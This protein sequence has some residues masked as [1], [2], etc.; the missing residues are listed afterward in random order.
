MNK[1]SI[2]SN[3]I[4]RFAER[5][6]AQFVTFF[7]SIILAR[8]LEPKVYGTVAIVTIFITIL[9]VFVD[10][11]LGNA[12][13]QKKDADSKDY[14]SVFY[15][16]IVFCIVIYILLF[17]A[18]PLI[19]AFYNLPELTSMIRVMGFTIIISGI[20]NVQQ[21]YVSKNMMFKKFFFSTLIGT[22][23]AA[24]VGIYM[25]FAGFGVWAII[26][27]NLVNQ[28]IDT[29]ILWKTVKWRPTREF[30]FSRLKSLFSYG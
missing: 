20:K 9:Q 12:L 29:A 21:A 26:V 7:V 30:S 27:Q 13:I 16:N 3:L 6:G 18:A 14:S 4:W 11:G 1:N 5:C 22:I 28:L 24:V 8:L 23:V 17:L 10:S 19:S 15:A 2:F 25:A